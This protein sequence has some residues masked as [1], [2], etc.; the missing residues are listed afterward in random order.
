MDTALRPESMKRPGPRPIYV[1]AQEIRKEWGQKINFAARP[2]LVAMLSLNKI[3]DDT[4]QSVVLYFLS[5]ASTWRGDA[6]RR[7]K[8]ELKAICA[9]K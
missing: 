9:L 7:I 4:G 1:I 6:A 8:K 2:Y 5:N 3:S